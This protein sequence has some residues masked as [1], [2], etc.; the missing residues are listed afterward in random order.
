MASPETG[1]HIRYGTA[2]DIQAGRN[3]PVGQVA[4]KFKANQFVNLLIR[5]LNLA[6][7]T[8]LRKLGY[9]E[10]MLSIVLKVKSAGFRR[11]DHRFQQMVRFG[12]NKSESMV[13][14]DQNMQMSRL[15]DRITY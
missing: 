14:L 9:Q 7:A 2:P 12:R 4:V 8:R 13:G 11:Q 5:V 10:K 15:F 1:D 3:A 6:M